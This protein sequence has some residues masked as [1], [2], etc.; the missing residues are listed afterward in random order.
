[1]FIFSLS[2]VFMEINARWIIRLIIGISFCIPLIIDGTTQLYQ[3]R[4]STNGI[5]LLTGLF[6]GLG[7]SLIWLPG[8]LR[9]F[10]NILYRKIKRNERRFNNM[11]KVTQN[12]SVLLFV[13]FVVFISTE[14]ASL[15]AE[16]TIKAGTPIPIRLEES[17]T[18][19][20]ATTGQSVR[21]T[22]T[23]DVKV[24][25]VVV[26]KAGSPVD[27]EVSFA[28]KTGSLGKEGKVFVVVRYAMAVDGTK[29]PLRASLSK[30]GDEKVALSWMVC[31]FIKGTGGEIQANTETKA[32]VDY[33]TKINI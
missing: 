24:D 25:G 12:I 16:I 33:D 13:I 26:I 14:T 28:Q 19:E 8:Y 23:R 29:V 6:A 17:V 18:S 32:Y 31:P 22:V 1:M 9:F 20:T 7:L 30:S 5:R 11:K 27:A 15:S 21:F 10:T 2:S 3:L 4:M